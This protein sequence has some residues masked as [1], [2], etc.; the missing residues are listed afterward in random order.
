[1]KATEVE[2]KVEKTT[3]S[4][5]EE[6]TAVES[7]F[8]TTEENATDKLVESKKEFSGTRTVEEV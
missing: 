3:S 6:S 8:M 2:S 7:S 1:L 4:S 5:T